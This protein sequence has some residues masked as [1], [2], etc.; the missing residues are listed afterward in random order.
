MPSSSERLSFSR[1][2]FMR[3]SSGIGTGI[4]LVIRSWKHGLAQLGEGIAVAGG[5]GVCTDFQEIGDLSKGEVAPD[6]Q[7]DDRS[8]IVGQNGEGVAKVMLGGIVA[9]RRGGPCWV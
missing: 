7:D 8:L 3:S 2:S 4:L 9:V 1:S 6:V 5:R